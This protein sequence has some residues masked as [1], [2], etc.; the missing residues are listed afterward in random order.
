M[1][2]RFI[3]G[4]PV[5]N[6]ARWVVNITRELDNMECGFSTNV[7][8]EIA[9]IR[10]AIKNKSTFELVVIIVPLCS[11]SYY[12]Q[13]N[14][15]MPWTDPGVHKLI[16]KLSPAQCHL[17]FSFAG[18]RLALFPLNPSPTPPLPATHESILRVNSLL[19]EIQYGPTVCS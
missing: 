18:L 19:V 2:R 6:I 4:I 7:L 8:Q 16:A 5:Q 12:V 11:T 3:D 15:R 14:G 10:N 13:S 17:S 1:I 9:P